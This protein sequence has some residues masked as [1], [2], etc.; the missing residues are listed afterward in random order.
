MKQDNQM[1]LTFRCPP[2][3]GAMIARCLLANASA[4]D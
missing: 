1:T 4:R 3:I 2:F